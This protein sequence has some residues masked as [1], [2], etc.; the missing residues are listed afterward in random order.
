[1]HD[2]DTFEGWVKYQQLDLHGQPEETVAIARLAF[3]TAKARRAAARSAVAF[4]Q[5]CPA[6]EY[7][8][9]VAIADG[10]DLRLAL[11]IRRS[12]KAECFILYPRD[13]EWDPHSSYHHDGKYHHKSHGQKMGIVSPRQRLDQFVGTE[14]LGSFLGF[15][16]A[17]PIC[18]PANF[19]SVL[20]VPTGILGSTHGRV[21]VDLVQPGVRPNSLHR[22]GLQIIREETYVDCSPGVVIAITA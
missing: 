9:A 7:R 6:G 17:A 8:Y 13:G 1:M 21:L 19:T 2:L 4:N 10:A 20:K 22:D 5:P 12:R 14:H 15:G 3:E 16:T 11:V 18:D